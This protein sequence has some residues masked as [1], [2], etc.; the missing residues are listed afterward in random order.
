MKPEGHLPHL[1]AW[2]CKSCKARQLSLQRAGWRASSFLRGDSVHLEQEVKGK[3]WEELSVDSRRQCGTVPG[4]GDEYRVDKKRGTV[5]TVEESIQEGERWLKVL[6]S[7][8]AWHPSEHV[9]KW[10]LPRCSQCRYR[11][12]K[13]G[14][15]VGQ[16]ALVV[17]P[18]ASWGPL[19]HSCQ[20]WCET[21][22]GRPYSQYVSGNP[23]EVWRP[24]KGVLLPCEAGST[25]RVDLK[26]SIW[27]W[28]WKW[29]EE[30][31][32]QGY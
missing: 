32:S 21:R 12:Y 25:I 30:Q 4:I 31:M 22:D 13:A 17:L 24:G 5:E 6:A 20:W 18:A 23:R 19:F 9:A 26:A 14:S 16:W 29:V 1:Q 8:G 11:R 10:G 7:C 3:F 28:C 15:V 2:C 27:K